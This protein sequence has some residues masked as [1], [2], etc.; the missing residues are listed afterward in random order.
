MHLRLGLKPFS[1]PRSVVV[2]TAAGVIALSAS[3]GAVAGGLITGKQIKANTI[4]SKNIKNGTIT[5]A[6]LA[7]GTAITG[8]QGPAGAAGAAG[9]PGI[10][11]YQ[12]I[13][14]SK[15]VAAGVA[16]ELDLDC[17]SGK[18]LLS[19]AAWLYDGLDAIQ[20]ATDTTGASAFTPAL[21]TSDTAYLTV[22]CANVTS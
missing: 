5:A 22:F 21:A 2:L 8:P 6:D 20:V 3:G 7:P 10:A 11:G 9:A 4:T 1:L 12:E 17:P 16:D 14:T 15:A 18:K 19:A 13:T